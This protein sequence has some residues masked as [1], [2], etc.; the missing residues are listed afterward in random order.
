MSNLWVFFQLIPA[1]DDAKDLV[2]KLFSSTLQDVARIWY[3]S[4]PNAI[5]KTMDQ[6]EHVFLKRWS[7]KEDYNML[8][9]RLNDI[10]KSD[11]ETVMEF[12]AN[13]EILLQQIPRIHH[14]EGD[15]L[16][17]IYIKDLLGKFGFM[18][19]DK[20][21]RKIQ[22]SHETITKIEDNLSSSKVEPYC[23]PRTKVDIKLKVVHSVK[24]TQ[25]INTTLEKIQETMDGMA[26]NQTLMM[27]IITNLERAQ[28]QAL[29]PPFNGQ[30][31]NSGQ[32]YKP[33]NEQRVPDTLT[34]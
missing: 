14:P 28:Q 32:L 18:L 7:V 10:K 21:P 1:S 2:M 13:F 4:L 12:Q 3:D 23:A 15:Y 9:R 27:N 26:R 31:Q 20:G 24:T 8:L 17:F 29:M 6:L 5:I 33:R 30:P 22:E 34:P 11:N 16:L 19:R 25:D